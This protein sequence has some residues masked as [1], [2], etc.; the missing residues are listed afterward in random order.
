M[1]MAFLTAVIKRRLFPHR[2]HP[3]NYCNLASVASLVAVIIRDPGIADSSC[4]D[5]PY[6]LDPGSQLQLIG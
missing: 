1:S 6:I 3:G 2:R 4:N 5:K